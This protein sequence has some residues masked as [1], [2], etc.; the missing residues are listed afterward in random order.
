MSHPT[1]SFDLYLCGPSLSSTGFPPKGGH[2][3]N[4]IKDLLRSELK[5][6][7]IFEADLNIK[8]NASLFHQLVPESSLKTRH[9]EQIK[10]YVYLQG[11]WNFSCKKRPKLTN[12]NNDSGSG[13]SDDESGTSTDIVDTDAEALDSEC[14]GII[15]QDTDGT[16]SCDEYD[17]TAEPGSKRGQFAN[18]PIPDPYIAQKPDIALFYYKSKAYEKTWI[19]VLSFVE[20]T[21]SDF[22]KRYSIM[23]VLL[24]GQGLFCCGMACYHV[25]DPVDGKE[26]AMKD[27]WVTEVKRYHEVDVLERV[28]GIPNVVQLIDHWDVQFNGEPDCTACIWDGYGALLGDRLDKRFCNRD[29]LWDFSSRKELIC[30]FHDFMV[31]ISYFIDFDHTSIIKEGETFTV[32]F[33]TGTVPYISMHILKKMSK[34]ADIIKKSKTTIDTKK[35]NSNTNSITQLELYSRAHGTLAP[36]WDKTTM[37]WA[38]AYE[39]LGTTSG[40]LATFLVKKGAMSEDDILMDR[41]SEYFTEFKPIINKWCTQIH[42]MESNLEGAIIHEHIFQMLAKFIT[43]LNNEEP[44]PLPSPPLPVAPPSAPNAIMIMSSGTMPPRK[45]PRC[46]SPDLEAPAHQSSRPNCGVGGHAAQLQRVGETVAAPTRKGLKGNDLQISSSEENPMAPSQLQKGKKKNKIASILRLPLPIQINMWLT[47]LKG[48]DSRNL[49]LMV[50]KQ[51]EGINM[52]MDRYADNGMDFDKNMDQPCPDNE[53]Q[54]GVEPVASND[55]LTDPEQDEAYDVLKHHHAKNGQQKAPSLTYLLKGKGKEQAHTF[56]LPGGAS[57]VQVMAKLEMQL[58]AVL[59]TPVPESQ[60]ALNLAR[61]VLDTVLWTYHEK[62]IKLERELKKIVVSIA[63]RAYNIFLQGSTGNFKNFMVQAL[64]DA[65]LEFYYS[66]SK[67]ALK[68]MDEFHQTIPINAMLLV[69]VV[70]KGIISGFHETGT[71]KVPELTAE[72]CRA[73]FVN[74]WKSIDTLL[75]VPEHHEELEDMLEQWARIGMGDFN[76]YADGSTIITTVWIMFTV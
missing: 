17:G 76:E 70:L 29:P 23:A 15:S 57:T 46:S 38:D 45:K 49:G 11:V 12:Q 37:P 75:D 68:N 39:N 7:V 72:Q 28:K 50:T 66:N 6:H 59:A 73:H 9:I 16:W 21:T 2:T 31:G 41:V 27:C 65:C 35:S 14:S 13:D 52:P 74:L 20:H 36:T 54:G 43:K 67:K 48:L 19:D 44:S 33:G 62:K 47:L 24:K 5:G 1:T 69:A 61:E 51:L 4:L 10:Y 8:D 56:K 25:Q 64:K 18:S 34:N 26:Y 58:Q 53:A 42:H 71:N 40:L 32:S 55:K 3:Y 22:S 63:K 30:T 60:E